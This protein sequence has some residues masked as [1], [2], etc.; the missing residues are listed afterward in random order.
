MNDYMKSL[1]T[2]SKGRKKIL[3]VLLKFGEV[4][5]S[6]IIKHTMLNHKIVNTYL[7]EMVSL[8]LVKER[9]FGRVRMF[10]LSDSE[11]L[12]QMLRNADGSKTSS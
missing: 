5:I 12:M 10:R 2:F 6:R 7:R 11:L 8:G 3:E 1:M 4:N 9:K